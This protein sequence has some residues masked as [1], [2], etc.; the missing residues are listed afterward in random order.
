MAASW[1][2]GSN[3][4][5]IRHNTLAEMNNWSCSLSSWPFICDNVPRGMEWVALSDYSGYWF[6]GIPDARTTL[7]SPLSL[8][9][10]GSCQRMQ[11]QCTRLLASKAITAH[12]IWDEYC[13]TSWPIIHFHAFVYW[14]SPINPILACFIILSLISR[15]PI[16]KRLLRFRPS[17]QTSRL[18][19]HAL[20]HSYQTPRQRGRMSNK[21]YICCF[22]LIV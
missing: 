16:K 3:P 18:F 8:G 22:Q 6:N 5:L 17:L 19:P 4:H 9:P 21:V 20:A 15:L 10:P 1:A 2:F 7:A 14:I 13:P 12:R 11:V